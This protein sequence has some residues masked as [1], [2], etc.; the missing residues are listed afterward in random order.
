MNFLSVLVSLMTY[1]NHIPLLD[2]SISTILDDEKEGKINSSSFFE[3]F[4]L[5]LR[6]KFWEIIIDS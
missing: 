5:T 4:Y 6:R 1:L 2:A 3:G